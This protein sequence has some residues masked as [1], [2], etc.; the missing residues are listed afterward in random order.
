MAVASLCDVVVTAGSFP[1]LSGV[2]LT[3]E[4]TVTYV[5]TGSNGAGKT[6][7]LR[8]LAGLEAPSRGSGTVL[9]FDIC[10]S[11]RRELRRHVGWLG[12]EMSFYADL[13]PVENLKFAARTTGADVAAITPALDRVGLA[14]R[15]KVPMK[16]LSAGQQRR[17]SMAWFMV[18][19]PQL[20]LMDEPYAS[21]DDEGRDLLSELLVTAQTSGATIVLT[22]HGL[23]PPEIDAASIVMVGGRIAK[24]AS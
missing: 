13:S 9:G 3:L 6:S 11:Q 2:T 21:L 14:Q 5:I 17:V 1:L 8:L 20:W 15:S 22:S 16:F 12:H 10:S 4:P 23:L 18:R 24:V 7:L 19:R